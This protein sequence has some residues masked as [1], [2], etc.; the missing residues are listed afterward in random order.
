MCFLEDL[1][2]D[3]TCHSGSATS[4]GLAEADGNG[5]AGSIPHWCRA[6]RPSSNV[7]T[8][9]PLWIMERVAQVLQFVH[10]L[11]V[12]EGFCYCCQIASSLEGVSG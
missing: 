7:V 11:V 5:V 3:T 8:V 12:P 4:S 6:L 2:R 9:T 10:N 1:L